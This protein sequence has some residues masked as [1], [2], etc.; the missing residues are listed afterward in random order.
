MISE[1]VATL[2]IIDIV[3]IALALLMFKY[4]SPDGIFQR[5]PRGRALIVLGVVTLSLFYAADL[6][7][8]RVGSLFIGEA[9]ALEVMNSLHREV[10]WLATV[11]SVALIVIGF[12]LTN[13]AR[14]RDE[15]RLSLMT[16]ALPL[17]VA[18]IDAEERYRFANSHYAK[19][20][21]KNTRC[22]AKGSHT[23]IVD[24]SR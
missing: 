3:V 13:R 19:L 24:P 15:E 1:S 16:D 5:W 8:M 12:Q 17:A 6:L 20:H 9:R 10:L 2:T 7:V 23:S 18:Y 14:T 4:A 22:V 21:A 11:L